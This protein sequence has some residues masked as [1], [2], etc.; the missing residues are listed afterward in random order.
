MRTTFK[1]LTVGLLAAAPLVLAAAPAHALTNVTLTGGLLS[2]NSGTVSDNITIKVV[3]TTIE[4]VNTNDT[5]ITNFACAQVNPNTVRCPSASVSRIVANV[6]DG[7]DIV[8]NNTALPL[9]AFLGIGSDQY[10][11]GSNQDRVSGDFGRD[12]MV[13]NGGNDIMDGGPGVDSADGG[14]G[15]DVCVAES[16]VACELN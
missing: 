15:T 13:G 8:R 12:T 10:F 9:Q 3:G 1:A 4:V 14:S 16:E 11:G 7:S 2:I 5:L 6:K